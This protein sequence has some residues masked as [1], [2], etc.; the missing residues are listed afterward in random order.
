MVREGGLM[1]IHL[2]WLQLQHLEAPPMEEHIPKPN[3]S[4]HFRSDG[5]R[6]GPRG[7]RMLLPAHNNQRVQALGDEK[8]STIVLLSSSKDAY[9]P[10]F[11]AC[12]CKVGWTTI[13]ASCKK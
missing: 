2:V 11:M 3:L 5:Y 8:T 4:I 12:K 10:N 7:P 1:L 6:A 9:K 13:F